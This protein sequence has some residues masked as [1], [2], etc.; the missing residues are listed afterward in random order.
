MKKLLT[1]L[2]TL[3]VLAGCAKSETKTDDTA[4]S[5]QTEVETNDTDVVTTSSKDHPWLD[6]ESIAEA[7][8]LMGFKLFDIDEVE[9]NAR[10]AIQYLNNKEGIKAVQ[11]IFGDEVKLRKAELAAGDDIS[12]DYNE[13]SYTEEV[14][15]D[16]NFTIKGNEEG[17]VNNAAW[18]TENNTYSITSVSGLPLETVK[19]L[20]VTMTS[21]E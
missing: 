9:G 16:V 18:K 13:Y 8:E 6:C 20:V 14:E 11:L 3:L 17:V 1:I 4:N 15:G 19:T 7:E 10:T 2:L 12:G 5:D 21:Y